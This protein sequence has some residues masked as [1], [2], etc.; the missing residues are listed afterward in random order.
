MTEYRWHHAAIESVSISH[1]QKFS[2]AWIVASERAPA[3]LYQQ[4]PDALRK[5]GL[6]VFADIC[7]GRPALRVRGFASDEVL[8]KLLEQ[9][10][11]VR[12]AA[13][14]V[15][16]D[17]D[18][19]KQGVDAAKEWLSEHSMA[20]SGVAYLI[21]DGFA[22]MSGWQRDNSHGMAQGLLWAAASAM[23]VLFGTR[24]PKHQMETL[25]N[26][27]QEHFRQN[28]IKLSPQEEYALQQMRGHPE[29]FYNRLV[30]FIYE[31][32]VEINNTLQGWGGYK[33]IQAGMTQMQSN[34][35]ALL[36]DIHASGIKR[37]N[38]YKMLAGFCV[39]GGFWASMFVH[40]DPEVKL[41][42]E[43]KNKRF[44]DRLEGKEPA[45][46]K[47]VS[48]FE[49]PV[50]WVKQKPLRLA[51][52]GAMINNAAVFLGALLYERPNVQSYLGK[53]E[54]IA[55]TWNKDATQA[56]FQAV[57]KEQMNRH[58][59][60]KYDLLTAPFNL[61][62]NQLYAISP[63]DR[64][65]KLK[66]T[67]YLDELYTLAANVYSAMP[68]AEAD[69]RIEAF[70]GHMSN[71]AEMKSSAKEIAGHVREKM[72]QLANNPWLQASPAPQIPATEASEIAHLQKGLG[73]QTAQQ[74]TL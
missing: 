20:A 32:P 27:M 39:A 5:A 74:V 35:D 69:K 38:Y 2:S 55:A 72:V 1:A 16:K 14:E 19:S 43:E 34:A 71:R 4:L 63:A 42:E 49:D 44:L 10:Q 73:A 8:L 47:D 64:R 37:P 40:E 9:S 12:G 56:V 46:V 52:Y 50:A 54:A 22:F 28:G 15:V 62:A 51:G 7:D 31:H 65:G 18:T 6:Q 24:D 30:N 29:D 70:A 53:R 21:A 67:G 45:P 17:I 61:I 58:Y 66:E 48:L 57:D 36:A 23:L 26:H 41:S 60:L 68:E 13:N 59:A 11:A 33:L 3:E 25:Y